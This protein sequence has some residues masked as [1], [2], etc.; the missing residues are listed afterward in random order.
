MSQKAGALNPRAGKNSAVA[1][2]APRL[3]VEALD[4]L[5]LNA[6]LLPLISTKDT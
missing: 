4:E 3:R 5:R 1:Q 6:S 2:A